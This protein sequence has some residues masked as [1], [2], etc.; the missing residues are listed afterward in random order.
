MK[1]N[2]VHD[3]RLYESIATNYWCII[4]TLLDIKIQEKIGK[5]FQTSHRSREAPLWPKGKF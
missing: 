1:A 4:N 3:R 5:S 2:V